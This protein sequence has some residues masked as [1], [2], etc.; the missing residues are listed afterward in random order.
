MAD[1][2]CTYHLASAPHGHL[3][4]DTCG[5]MTEIAGEVFSDLAA[6]AS[7]RHG[8]TIDPHRFAVTGRCSRCR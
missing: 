8:F 1:G 6:T 3:V 7:T 5:S 2:L 4:R